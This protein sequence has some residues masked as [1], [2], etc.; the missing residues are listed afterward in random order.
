MSQ[1]LRSTRNQYICLPEHQYAFEEIK[2]ELAKPTCIAHFDP[3]L[4]TRLERD[5]SPKKGFGYAFLQKHDYGWKI[6]AAGS[7]CLTDVET[8]CAMVEIE[9]IAILLLYFMK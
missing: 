6:V 1:P 4:E 5:A 9:L 3:Q 8:R 7:M 2:L